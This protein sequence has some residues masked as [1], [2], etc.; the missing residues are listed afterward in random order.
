MEEKITYRLFDPED[1]KATVALYQAVYGEKY[2]IKEMY[3]PQHLVW[4]YELGDTH[5]MLA[6]TETGEVVGHIA[7]YRS[8]PPNR[9]LYELGQMII[10][11]DYRRSTIA[12]ELFPAIAAE[13]PVCCELDG[14]WGEAVCNHLFTQQMV[15][16]EG[17]CE[18]GIEIGLMPPEAG[19]TA[20]NQSRASAERGSVVVGF[21][22]HQQRPQKIFIP[23]AYEEALQ[24][25]YEGTGTTHEWILTES[26]LPNCVSTEGSVQTFPEAGIARITFFTIGEDFERVLS[27]K[28][29]EASQSGAVVTQVIL[30]LTDFGIGT[31]VDMLRQ[32]QYFLGAVLPAW[33]GDDGLMLQKLLPTPDFN[34]IQLYTP[35]ARR[36]LEI[37]RQDFLAVYTLKTVD[38]ERL[39]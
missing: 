19:A 28:E 14:I 7:L 29:C 35:R 12:F 30:Q 31:A 38:H 16:R 39:L 6:V 10:R 26:Q 22:I 8:S 9:R 2:P 24:F 37:I 36:L 25:F 4:Q 18:T 15:V 27:I 20:M 32:R 1:A 21:Q 17:F 33:F 13:I 23:P 11:R 3:D 34:Q 5:R